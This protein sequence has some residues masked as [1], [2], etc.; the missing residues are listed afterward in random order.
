MEEETT[1]MDKPSDENTGKTTEA[2]TICNPN[3]FPAWVLNTG[4]ITGLLLAGFCLLLSAY[5]MINFQNLSSAGINQVVE[6]TMATGSPNLPTAHTL[7]GNDYQMVRVALATNMYIARILLLSCGIFVGMAFGFMGFSLFLVGV[8]GD[9]DASLS[10]TDKYKLQVARLSPGL[11]VI[12][13]ATILIGMCA[14][15]SL[16]VDMNQ[17]NADEFGI[18][19][20]KKDSID[21]LLDSIK[22]HPEPGRDTTMPQ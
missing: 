15:K 14:T 9:I 21:K 22:I 16:P 19:Q 5:Y 18:K 2:S 13:C 8:K 1:I 11:F 10:A 20:Y 12:L 3:I 17:K 4:F 6:R 7:T